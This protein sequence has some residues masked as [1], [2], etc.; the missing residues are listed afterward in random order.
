MWWVERSSIYFQWE[1]LII[2][3]HYVFKTIK[4]QNCDRKCSLHF[5]LSNFKTFQ[6]SNNWS[7][8]WMYALFASEF[9]FF[10]ATKHHGNPAE[11]C[12]VTVFI[13]INLT[14]LV[15]TR[16]S[17]FLPFPMKL[18]RGESR[19]YYRQVLPYN[20]K[21]WAS[22]NGKPGFYRRLETSRHTWILQH[23]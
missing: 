16:S 23:Y 3:L 1:Y 18:F 17:L 6:F 15:T 2:W 11:N 5:N 9:C 21:S 14:C 19:P 12:P 22:R 13:S 7:K 4:I 20:E 10:L 8:F